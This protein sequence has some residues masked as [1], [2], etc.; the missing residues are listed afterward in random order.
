MTDDAPTQPFIYEGLDPAPKSKC[1]IEEIDPTPLKA[2]RS[3]PRQ[4]RHKK[5]FKSPSM[6]LS[7]PQQHRARGAAR[8]K[9]ISSL[10]LLAGRRGRPAAVKRSTALIVAPPAA[11]RNYFPIYRNNA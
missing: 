11:A 1:T 5:P 6:P 9:K 10:P 2:R 4:Q 8:I 7:I 3:Q